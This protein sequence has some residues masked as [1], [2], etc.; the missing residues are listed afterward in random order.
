[1]KAF[2]VFEGILMPFYCNIIFQLFI[3]DIQKQIWL[4]YLTFYSVEFIKFI[5]LN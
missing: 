5:L 2:V 1:M 4:L 3:A